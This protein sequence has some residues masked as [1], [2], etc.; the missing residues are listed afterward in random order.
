M[1][2]NT[3]FFKKDNEIYESIVLVRKLL[4]ALESRLGDLDALI[5]KADAEKRRKERL[6]FV[7][8]S[9]NKAL[10]TSSPNKKPVQPKPYI[11]R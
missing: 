7:N 1:E 11:S 8:K 2:K 10:P 9:L 3:F 6:A 4:T 5:K